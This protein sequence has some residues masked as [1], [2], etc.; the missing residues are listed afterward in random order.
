M[1]NGTCGRPSLAGAPMTSSI[2]TSGFGDAYR[3]LGVRGLPITEILGHVIVLPVTASE[4]RCIE[5]LMLSFVVIFVFFA[6]AASQMLC[7]I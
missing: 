2:T 4:L 5:Q 1:D 6:H 7:H 3:F